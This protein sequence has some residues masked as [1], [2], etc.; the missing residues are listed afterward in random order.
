[1]PNQAQ[2]P[3]PTAPTDGPILRRVAAAKPNV[4]ASSPRICTWCGEVVDGLA[5]RACARRRA[6]AAL[7][8]AMPAAGERFRA[9]V[10]VEYGDATL[11][12]FAPA[13]LNRALA[14][15]RRHR[16]GEPFY[17][18]LIAGPYGVGKTH[19]AAAAARLWVLAG[20]SFRWIPVRE[21]FSEVRA[22]YQDGAAASELEVVAAHT[23]ADVLV[24]D[25]LGRE[26]S[27]DGRATDQVQSLLHAILDER[28]RHR[29][30]TFVT[31]NLVGAEIAH[32]Y[33]GA[34]ASRLALFD[35]LVIRG[36]DR[37]QELA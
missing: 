36:E 34:I 29:R 20:A 21:L 14:A 2:Q 27:R 7:W 19:F 3:M 30:P 25:D 35:H 4:T 24:M 37:R 22:T 9:A 13:T 33:D 15:H 10:G 23:S 18:F 31:T 26:G 8:D 5:C 28:I 32:R 12:D 6:E 17:G 1:M 11:A 16:A